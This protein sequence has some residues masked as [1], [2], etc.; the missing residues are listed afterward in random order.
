MYVQNNIET[1]T[2]DWSQDSMREF[3]ALRDL[4][5]LF[6]ENNTVDLIDQI[7]LDELLKDIIHTK[8]H[9]YVQKAI[10]KFPPLNTNPSIMTFL[11]Q[12][13]RDICKLPRKK[14]N[15]QNLT[16]E[17]NKA[18][19]SLCNNVAIVIKPS[20]KA[21]NV[22]LMDNQDYKSMCQKILKNKDWY[23]SIPVRF[24]DQYNKKFYTVVDQA[25]EEGII[26]KDLY[27]FVRTKHPKVAFYSL[28]KIHKDPSR[29][30]RRL[31]VSRN[32]GNF[33]K[34]Q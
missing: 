29:P 11:K 1:D 12:T 20:D 22:V 15:L 4:T 8:F 30:S 33:R 34:P 16:I 23:R 9:Q 18:L 13:I 6:Q 21:G 31:I 7:D 17:E 3:K 5:L 24:I 19:E 10:T 27:E 14:N 32:G 28:P 26:P 25:Y 2:T